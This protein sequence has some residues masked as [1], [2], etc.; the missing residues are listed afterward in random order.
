[1]REGTGHATLDGLELPFECTLRGPLQLEVERGVDAHPFLVDGLAELGLELLAYPLHVVRRDLPR[2]AAPVRQAQR[3]GLGQ[4]SI[5]IADGTSASHQLQDGV[6]AL[7]GALGKAARVITPGRL[8]Q[9]GD[10]GRLGEVDVAHRLAEVAL[11][12]RLDAVGAA[13]QVDLV[14]V[15]LENVVLAVLRLDGPRDLGFTQ[16]ADDGLLAR[17]LPRI[18]VARQLPRIDVAR[19]L[20]GDGRESLGESAAPQVAEAGAQHADEID[21]AVLVEPLVLRDDEGFP[22]DLRDLVDGHERAAFE[23]H[24]G[25]EPAVSGEELGRLARAVLVEPAD[26]RAL[27]ATADEE[28]SER[29]ETHGH[30]GDDGAGDEGVAERL[31]HY[32]GIYGGGRRRVSWRPAANCLPPAPYHVALPPVA[33]AHAS[34]PRHRLLGSHRL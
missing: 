15:E 13:P 28:P 26:G 9:R 14:E 16:L 32:A 29:D 19:Q 27:V 5:G 24:F 6:A 25:H 11:T 18:N 34:P 3:I 7:D 8:G 31:A 2:N 17:P 20:H 12:G 10:G 22:Q 30:R 1:M 33:F 23:A 21:A 4:R